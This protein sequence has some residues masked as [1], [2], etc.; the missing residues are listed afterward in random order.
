MTAS[1]SSSDAPLPTRPGRPAPTTTVHG[2]ARP[3]PVA[4]RAGHLLG[5]AVD[6]ALL[7]AVTVW[8]GWE[9]VPFL[10]DDF[11]DV[12]GL[13]SASLVLNAVAELVYA[14]V[15]RP[16]VK[17]VGDVVT[18]SVSL[19]VTVRLWQVFPFTFADGT[20]W[21]VVARVL[22]GVALVGTAIGIVVA[23]VT[24]VRPSREP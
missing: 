3:G 23:L 11:R 10:D 16:R 9:V 4:R 18:L 17:A 19:V 22:L 21:A 24:A 20:P 15:D 1:A 5:A 7:V 8:P 6:V 2:R 12:V 13:L 14:V